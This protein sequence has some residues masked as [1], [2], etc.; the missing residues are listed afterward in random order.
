MDRRTAKTES[1]A[2][3]SM[4]SSIDKEE[5]G[6]MRCGRIMLLCKGA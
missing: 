2:K 5:T 6:G 4:N 3:S 1:Q